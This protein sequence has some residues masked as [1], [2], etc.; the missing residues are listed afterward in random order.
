MVDTVDITPTPRIL[1]TL[2]D[3]P[4]EVWQ[5]L[6]ELADNSLDAF[7]DVVK[8]G[9]SLEDARID[10]FW[11]KED[12]ASTERE[13]IIQ[14][15]GPGMP[16]SVLRNAAKAGYSSNDPVNN[17]GLFGM[18]FNISTARLGEETVF[19]SATKDAKEWTGIVIDFAELIA[20]GSFEARV[21]SEPK[22]HST[23][24]GTKIIIKR[25]RDG[26]YSDL[27]NKESAI[28]RR[29]EVIYSNILEKDDVEIRLQG[30]TLRPHRHCVWGETRFVMYKG[31]RVHAVQ[32]IDMDLGS[33]YFDQS[34]NR[35][36]SEA[37]IDS[38]GDKSLS[39]DIVKRQRRLKGWV[40]IQRYFDPAD[41]GIDFIRNGRKILIGDKTLFGYENLDTGTRIME[42]PIE[43]ASTVGGR[44]VGEIHVD[45]LIPTYQKNGF[46]TSN[47]AWKTTI[48]ALRGAGPILPKQRQALGYDGDN[49]SPI[50][51]L[52][53]AFRRGDPG[54][55]TLSLRK[56]VARSLLTEFKKGT[57]DFQSD[58]KWYRA[59]QEEDKARAGENEDKSA[60]VDQGTSPS[61]DLE[62]YLGSTAQSSGVVVTQTIT[63][64]ANPPVTSEKGDLMSKSE[65]QVSLTSKF[66]YTNK[67]GFDV[68]SWKLKSPDRI[69]NQGRRVPCMIFQ[70]GV[71]V[72]FFYDETHPLLEEYPLTPKQLL[73]QVLAERFSTRDP[74]VSVQEAFWGLV[75]NHLT[76]ERIHPMSLR[77]RAD[78]VMGTIRDSLPQLLL[79]RSVKCLE[80]IRSSVAESDSLAQTLLEKAP[81]LFSAFQN[82]GDD[83]HKILAYVNEDTI[84]SFVSAM[85]EEFMDGKV[86]KLP[87]LDIDLHDEAVNE[88]LRKSSVDKII[89]YLRDVKLLL[90]ATGRPNKSELIRYANTLRVL[91]ERM[92]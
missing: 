24:S 84:I 21:V 91:S 14:D 46:D 6:A 1:R 68:T 12:T 92:A 49:L 7:R 23:E 3:I 59:L 26:I 53:N 9:T 31:A 51:I 33:A 25:L 35:Y 58:D 50:G 81:D 67:P 30:K 83:T 5:C 27:K 62:S 19:L 13:L 10:I 11:S 34:R 82:G 79:H 72:D 74:S 44:I 8:A 4:F 78:A 77:E 16:L 15:N 38:L 69:H 90:K 42:Y 20:K 54:T 55:K 52:A 37:E 73:L 17:L 75:D 71:E 86:F 85:P 36:L 28:R 43:L 41:F 45:Y 56:D 39:K 61:D 63:T 80:L 76:D 65:K 70:D 32:E 57:P 60:P 22:K 64:P 18:G 47:L 88:R 40:G 29:L 66:S 87:Y 89:S 2:G 48:D